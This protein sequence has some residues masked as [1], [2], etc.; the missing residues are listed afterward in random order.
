MVLDRKTYKKIEYYLYHYFQIRQEVER[1]KQDII[2]AR[3]RDLAEWGGGMSYHSDPTASKA[4]KLARPELVEKE[5][6]LRVIEK[7]I[8]HFQGAEK[9]RLL[10]KKYFGELGE[11][12]ICRELHIERATYFRWREEIVTYTAMLAL[13]EGLISMKV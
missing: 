8:Q 13:Q 9:G 5:K 10:Q 7:T 11:K 1:E 6:W 12:Q 4:V 3:G 2:E